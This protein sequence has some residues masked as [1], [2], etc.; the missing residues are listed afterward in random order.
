MSSRS[1]SL[2]LLVLVRR[3]TRRLGFTVSALIARRR[4]ALAAPPVPKHVRHAGRR[5]CGAIEAD[6]GCE[7]SA[8]GCI[9]ETD[10]D[11]E[12]MHG[13]DR[14]L[15]DPDGPA[16]S[17]SAVLNDV[18]A[19]TDLRRRGHQSPLGDE[20][21]RD[22]VCQRLLAQVG[23]VVGGLYHRLDY[24]QHPETNDYQCRE[25]LDQREPP[26]PAP[27]LQTGRQGPG[28]LG[29]THGRR[30]VSLC[31]SN[32]PSIVPAIRRISSVPSRRRRIS[33]GTTSPDASTRTCG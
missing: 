26:L 19:R 9:G 13:L 30:G 23:A 25:H 3:L 10:S 29:T 27:R 4:T 33:N 15:R 2:L 6:R 18:R 24:T 1:A 22:P 28:W 32:L 12:A 5:D 16:P 7:R 17:L 11:V 20:I 21:H 31:T 14:R 8:L